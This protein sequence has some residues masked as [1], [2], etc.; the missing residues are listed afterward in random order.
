MR[1]TLKHLH[2]VTYALPNTFT[3]ICIY[4][5]YL[6]VCLCSGFAP[7]W[8]LSQTGWGIYAPGL[9]DLLIYTKDTYVG[10]IRILS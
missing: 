4:I 8:P 5:Y 7:S 9:R 6:A 2:T 3:L 1:I 10:S